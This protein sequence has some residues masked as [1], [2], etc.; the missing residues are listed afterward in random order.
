MIPAGRE[1]ALLLAGMFG[2]PAAPLARTVAPGR[3]VRVGFGVSGGSAAP[4]P[5]P[6]AKPAPPPFRVLNR[7]GGWRWMRTLVEPWSRTY[8]TRHDAR[9]AAKAI[10]GVTP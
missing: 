8:R 2:A 7:N 6:R 5:K 1:A 10:L 3:T 9:R 4:P